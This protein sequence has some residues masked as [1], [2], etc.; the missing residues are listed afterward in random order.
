MK[1][2][3]FEVKCWCQ[4]SVPGHH[5]VVRIVKKYFGLVK[6]EKFDVNKTPRSFVRF[7][8]QVSTPNQLTNKIMT[9]ARDDL[10][11][12]LAPRLWLVGGD[13]YKDITLEFTILTKKDA[14]SIQPTS[15]FEDWRDIWMEKIQSKSMPLFASAEELLEW[16]E[17]VPNNLI[18]EILVEAGVDHPPTRK[19]REII[20]E[21]RENI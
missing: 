8:W 9:D 6:E 10:M 18:Q 19:L 17:K 3:V 16:V 7:E 11:D 15:S 1:T 4:T 14:G 20:D 21:I 2:T 5:D 12:Q 13:D